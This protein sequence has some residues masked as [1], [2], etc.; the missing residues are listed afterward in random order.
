MGA[1][2]ELPKNIEKTVDAKGC[3][4]MPGGI[5]PHTHLQAPFMGQV[6]CDDFNIGSQA[7]L[8]GGTTMVLLKLNY[9][10]FF[11]LICG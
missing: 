3:Y 9:F 11:L 7:A 1:D 4:V 6:S 2:L 5:D 8:A 10:T